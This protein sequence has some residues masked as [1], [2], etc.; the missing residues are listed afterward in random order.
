MAGVCRS[1][2]GR[3]CRGARWRRATLASQH[4]SL[5]SDSIAL[6]HPHSPIARQ[7]THKNGSRGCWGPQKVPGGARGGFLGDKSGVS[8]QGWEEFCECWVTTGDDWTAGE[9]GVP[10][11]ITPSPG[12]LATRHPPTHSSTPKT[13]PNPENHCK[14]AYI[15]CVL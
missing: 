15:Y 11:P 8:R 6:L 1:P 14:K 10:R 7:I 2:P 13:P 12:P 3:S 4:S 9:N 5:A